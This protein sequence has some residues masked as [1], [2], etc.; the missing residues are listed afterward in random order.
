MA[1][2]IYLV[3]EKQPFLMST[4]FLIKDKVKFLQI[5]RDISDKNTAKNMKRDSVS[6]YVHM[7]RDTS[8]SYTQLYT[9]WMKPPIPPPFAY[10]LN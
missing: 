4:S 3:G 10:A 8:S 7:R 1:A 9:F 6:A 2:E 5:K